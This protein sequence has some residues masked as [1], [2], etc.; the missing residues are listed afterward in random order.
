MKKLEKEV[1]FSEL[2]GEHKLSGI[3]FGIYEEDGDTKNTLDRNTVDFIID[4]NIYSAVENPDDGYRSSMRCLIKNRKIEIKN[5]FAPVRVIGKVLNE[6]NAESC[7]KPNILE[8][9][10]AK[11][12]KVVLEVGTGNAD[13]YYPYFVGVWTPENLSINEGKK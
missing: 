12:G 1:D 4:G 9:R 7:E 5:R 13:D 10:D 3:D 8:F 2:V 6:Y 11:N